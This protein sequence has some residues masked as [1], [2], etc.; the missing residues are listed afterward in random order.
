MKMY[1]IDRNGA[2]ILL[3]LNVTIEEA[4]MLWCRIGGLSHIPSVLDYNLSGFEVIE[5]GKLVYKGDYV[6]DEC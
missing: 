5:N 6:T 1:L 4:R 2:R 3:H